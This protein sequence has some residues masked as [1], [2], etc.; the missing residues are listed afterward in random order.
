LQGCHQ[1][2]NPQE[3]T[4]CRCC[5]SLKGAPGWIPEQMQQQA[6]ASRAA[7]TAAR[8]QLLLLPSLLP[9]LLQRWHVARCLAAAGVLWMA[10]GVLLCLQAC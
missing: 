6:A 1:V 3:Q 5:P 2:P 7:P 4:R 10:A 9:L 8:Q